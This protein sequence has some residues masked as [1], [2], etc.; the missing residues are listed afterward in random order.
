[1]KGLPV[2]TKN[3]M[4]LLESARLAIESETYDPITAEVLRMR[5]NN[6][7]EEMGAT[8]RNTSGSPILTE[9]NDFSTNI[10]DADAGV[11]ASGS[12]IIFHLGGATECVKSILER[13]P[14]ADLRPGDAI[15]MNDP[16]LGSPHKPDV[17][18]LTPVHYEGELVNWVWSA[19]HQYDVG[20]ISPG[21]FSP[22]VMDTYG[23]GMLIPPLKIAREG[24]I[25][26]D[27]RQM[28]EAN[29]RLGSQVFN[30][31]RCLIAANN[32]AL[33]RIQE[34]IEQYGLETYR[35]YCNITGL[36]SER[37]FRERIAQLPDGVYR[38]VD[39]VEHDGHE[40]ALY[41]VRCA[42]TVDGDTLDFDFEGTSPQAPGLVNCGPGGLLGN[43][44][45]PIIQMVCYDLEINF[46]LVQSVSINAAKGTI[47]NATEPAATGYG[48]LDAGYKVAK[49]VTE[50]LSQ[51]LQR[52]GDPWLQSRAMGQFNDSWS[53]ETWG[54]ADQHGKP[55][56]WLNM[57]GG[58]FGGGAQSVVDGMDVAGDLSSAGNAIPDIEWTEQMYPALHLWRRLEPNSGGPGSKR[59]GAGLDFAWTMWNS[60]SDS[61]TGAV[62]MAMSAIPSRGHGGGWPG[63][64]PRIIQLGDT[65]LGELLER[66]AWPTP[67]S[68]EAAEEFVSPPKHAPLTL[69]RGQVI[70]HFTGGG[71]GF[72]DPLL[73]G[74]NEVAREVASGWLTTGHAR[75]V[76]GVEATED[77][78]VD[79]PTTEK[80]RRSIRTTRLG[81]EAK[82]IPRPSK[83][84]GNANGKHTDDRLV[85]L[86]LKDDG[87]NIACLLCD[88]RLCGSDQDWR[89]HA[90]VVDQELSSRL[91]QVEM[92]AL[93]RQDGPIRF[94]EF[95][96]PGCGTALRTQ[97]TAKDVV[98]PDSVEPKTS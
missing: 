42:M 80:L 61:L 85:E 78:H 7:V 55:F 39:W 1:M 75:Q 52:S 88:T 30:D 9:A 2:E 43:I 5:L 18:I 69:H 73:R 34:A 35:L 47:I 68:L 81:Y 19:A 50:L 96:C 22:Q 93:L 41:E 54:G 23:E 20:G 28:I 56:A 36:L 62:I 77:G 53:V 83:S 12:F 72:G 65:N 25:N 89:D 79:A 67:D 14:K 13:Y 92:W 63:S 46:G 16:Y 87:S 37:A 60:K 48:H 64:A 71:A 59:G 11:Y 38:T 21:S 10:L 94:I 84:Q 95:F 26:D 57:D 97:V 90:R 32:V 86:Y 82:D 15:I 24:V 49:V 3:G 29:S 74:A 70:R 31:L 98:K 33:G 66:Q 6:I 45:S 51:A 27:L 76:Y 17:G 58:G 91:A 44:M 8:L 40:H 4:A